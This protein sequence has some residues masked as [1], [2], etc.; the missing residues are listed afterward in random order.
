M[1]YIIFK[2]KFNKIFP[3][4]FC[5]GYHIWLPVFTFKTIINFNR[6]ELNDFRWEYLIIRRYTDSLLSGYNLFCKFENNHF[7]TDFQIGTS[8]HAR[9]GKTMLSLIAM[10]GNQVFTTIRTNAIT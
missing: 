5:R 10:T 2:A 7:K 1:P 8:L 3:V 4:V 9:V 6:F